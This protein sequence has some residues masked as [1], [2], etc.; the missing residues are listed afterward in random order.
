MVDQFLDDLDEFTR[1]LPSLPSELRE[2]TDRLQRA[3]DSV[4]KLLAYPGELAREVMGYL[5][6]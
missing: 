4:G 2:W 1:G 5:K 3:K 6:M